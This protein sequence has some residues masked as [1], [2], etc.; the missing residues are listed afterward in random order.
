MEAEKFLSSLI[1]KTRAKLKLIRTD[2]WMMGHDRPGVGFPEPGL[3]TQTL[4]PRVC[5]C[6]RSEERG[7]QTF[8]AIPRLVYRGEDMEQAQILK[9]G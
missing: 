7:V 9:I 2:N 4:E 1:A 6:S 8:L 5:E 3:S